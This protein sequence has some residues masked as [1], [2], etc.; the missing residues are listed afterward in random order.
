MSSERWEE[1][2]AEIVKSG[3]GM[4]AMDSLRVACKRIE[5][6]ED[7]IADL[8]FDLRV[9]RD[10]QRCE[11]SAEDVCRFGRRIA[12]LEAA[13]IDLAQHVCD[14]CDGQGLYTLTSDNGE[15]ETGVCPCVGET[16]A[17]QRVEQRIAE[18]EAEN[19]RLRELIAR[20]D[21]AEGGLRIAVGLI[22]TM[23][24]HENKHPQEVYDWIMDLWEECAG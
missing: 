19:K 3:G 24:D 16:A 14:E 4:S 2:W 12:E 15:V 10:A 20:L 21:A 17:Y 5:D 11:C 6:M 7:C 1:I 9:A 18:L 13:N 23:P 8:E 22:S